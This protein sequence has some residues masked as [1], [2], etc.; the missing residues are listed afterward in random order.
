ME[1]EI[2]RTAVPPGIK[3][4]NA[5]A[6]QAPAVQSRQESTDVQGAG[7]SELATA[8]ITV[9]GSNNTAGGKEYLAAAQSSG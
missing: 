8:E 6:S 4:S 7:A 2:A 9:S 1:L 5:A 3:A